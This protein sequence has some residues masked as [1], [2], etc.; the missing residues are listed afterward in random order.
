MSTFVCFALLSWN[1]VIAP[2]EAE[3]VQ[4]ASVWD[5][6]QRDLQ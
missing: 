5:D 1:A 4:V 6:G 2:G 3:H